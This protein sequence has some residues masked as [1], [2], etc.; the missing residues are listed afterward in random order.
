MGHLTPAFEWS[1]VIGFCPGSC[2]VPRGADRACALTAWHGKNI[3]PAQYSP[4]RAPQFGSREEEPSGAASAPAAAGPGTAQRDGHQPGASWQQCHTSR[5]LWALFQPRMDLCVWQEAGEPTL[6][7]WL[8]LQ[9]HT[10]S[11][12]QFRTTGVSKINTD[13]SGCMLIAY[14]KYRP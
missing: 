1:L 2:A 13:P 14:S 9:P 8:N 11:L 12:G 3:P 5:D 4:V 7:G 6:L 10:A